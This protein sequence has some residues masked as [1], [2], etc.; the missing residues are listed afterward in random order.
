VRG[1]W[2][3]IIDIGSNSIRFVAYGG[4]RRVPAVLFNE[5]VMAGLGKGLNESGELAG[6][7]MARALVALR[8]FRLLS[9][10]LGLAD[11]QTVATAAVRDAR[12]GPAFMAQI[13][14]LGFEPTLIPGPREARLAGLGV[15][16]AIPDADGIAADLG[17]GSLEL[18]RGRGR[19]AGRVCRCP[20][21]CFACRPNRARFRRCAARSSARCRGPDLRAAAAGRRCIWSEGS[22]RALGLIDL[23]LSG[24]PLPIVHQHRLDA[25]ARVVELRGLIGRGRPAGRCGPFRLCRITHSHSA[26][27]RRA[28]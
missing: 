22:W 17:G 25:C 3:G 26:G 4:D 9:R 15:L 19:R 6:D 10:H 11:V 14:A 1:A 18:I 16:S 5:K 20:W 2:S 8:R 27:G 28:A 24:H 23:Q 7:A 12:N 13:A 21:A